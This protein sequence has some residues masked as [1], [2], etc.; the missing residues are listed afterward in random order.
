MT[1]AMRREFRLLSRESPWWLT[2]SVYCMLLGYGCWQSHGVVGAQR[3]QVEN[4]A[5]DYE[6][7]WDRIRHSLTARGER[8]WADARSP[9]LVGG[10]TGYAILRLPVDGLAAVSPGESQRRSRVRTISIYPSEPEPPIENPLITAAGPFDIAF[11]ALWLLPLALIAITHGAVSG[12]RDNG[13]WPMVA[14]HSASPARTALLRILLPSAALWAITAGAAAICVAVSGGTSAAGW[15]RFALWAVGLAGYTGFWVLLSAWVNS[16]ASSA[17]ASVRALG[18]VWLASVWLIPASID[19]MV[20]ALVPPVDR[21]QS[22]LAAREVRRDIEVKLPAMLDAVY[23][24]HPDWRPSPETVEAA[25]RPVP[26]GPAL[27]DSRRVYVPYLDSAEASRPHQERAAE[28]E[29]AAGR[30]ATKLGFVTPVLTFQALADALAG[31]SRKRF[32]EFEDAAR[33]A[34]TERHAFFAP[35]ILQL[36]EFTSEDLGRVPAFTPPAPFP[37]LDEAAAPA[38]GVALWCALGAVAVAGRFNRFNR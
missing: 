34:A 19:A 28:R 8:K 18:I 21:S 30:L 17:A 24:R 15:T 6:Q 20:A 16:R 33:W 7:R 2:M 13:T 4:A 29:A 10:S 3:A 31:T 37:S 27:R 22:H 12:S 14:L 35:L 23:E 5:L 9:S 11:V 36:R 32:L 26:G 25:R 1:R 38:A